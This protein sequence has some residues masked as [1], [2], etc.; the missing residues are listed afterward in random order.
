VEY[1][2]Y[3]VYCSTVLVFAFQN[4]DWCEKSS[5]CWCMGRISILGPTKYEVE[6]LNPT[7]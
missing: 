2:T 1:S 4:W 5:W 6:S 7:L 3:G